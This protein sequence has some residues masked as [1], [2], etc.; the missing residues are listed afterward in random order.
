MVK[1]GAPR[2][3]DHGREDMIMAIAEIKVWPVGTDNPSVSSFIR[4]CFEIAEQNDSIEA[5]LTP[6]STMLVGQ[7]PAQPCWP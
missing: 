7:L 2:L 1:R 4:D 3:W 6:T 5:I